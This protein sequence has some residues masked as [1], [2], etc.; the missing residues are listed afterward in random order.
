MLTVVGVIEDQRSPEG[1]MPSEGDQIVTQGGGN[2]EEPAITARV[3]GS[4]ADAVR[5]I[6]RIIEETSP[7]LHVV[8]SVPL[9]QTVDEARAP[10]RFLRLLLI[11]F[12]AC[13]LLLAAIGLYGVMAF[14]VAQRR[15]EIG[16]RMALGAGRGAIVSLVLRE[17]LG[18]TLA[19]LVAGCVGAVALARL[20]K[21]MLLG[22]T[23]ADPAS[24]V[25]ATAVVLAA[26]GVALWIPTRRALAVDVVQVVGGD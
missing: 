25:L 14:G 5:T 19:G 22:V 7:S 10:Q 9:R 20:L 24:Y 23:A 2:G 17:G 15:R 18:I 1:W 11:G 8:E 12:A 26:A 3:T 21:S 6:T 4:T 13:A 16:V